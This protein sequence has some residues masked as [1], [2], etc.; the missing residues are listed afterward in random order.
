MN[1]HCFADSG[2]VIRIRRTDACLY[3]QTRY[4]R[5]LKGYR[6]RMRAPL[7]LVV[8]P[9]T[10]FFFAVSGSRKL[11]AWSLAAGAAMA[12]ATTFA[13]NVRDDAPQHVLNW[14]RGAEG[15]R[16]T[17]KTLRRLERKGWVIE[18]D[19]QRDR[20]NLDHVVRGPRGV[21][22]LETKNLTGTITFEGGHL[23]ERQFD[24]PDEVYRY[25][26]LAGRARG[27]AMELSAR[28]GRETGRKPWVNGVIVLWG[29]FA[30]GRVE[31]ENATYIDGEQLALWLETLA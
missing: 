27:Q 28:L 6:R 25:R 13:M 14:R 20:P 16:R 29:H 18:H 11:D 2:L 10:I 22:L 7:L 31:H 12:T 23:V 4:R 15:E 19:I 17:A 30:A 24:D 1:T 3:A 9:L 21:F 8:V 26:L 5:G